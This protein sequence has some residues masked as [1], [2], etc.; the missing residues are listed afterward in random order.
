ML[1]TNA[2]FRRLF[3]ARV[4]SYVGDA[5]A[6]TAL[7]LR[8]EATLGV[9][10]AVGSLL[11][12]HAVPNGL[13]GPVA[14]AVVD[15]VDQRLLMVGADVGRALVFVVIAATLPPFPVLIA[16]MVVVAVLEA[17]F[18]PA[19]RSTIPSLVGRDHLMTA[20]A[21]MV[22]ALN[23]GVALGPLIGGGLV[24]A[25]GFSGALYVNAASFLL[26][27]AF[28]IGLPRIT[29]ERE[30]EEQRLGFFATTREGLA[31]AARDRMMRALSVGMILGVAAAGLDNV[32]LVF[33]A[34]RVFDAGPTGFGALESAFGIGMIV[35]SLLLVKRQP[36]TSSALFVLGWFG[37]AVGNFGV[38]IAP[39]ISFALL[40]Q[41]AGGVGNGVCLVG[42]DTLIQE[43]VPKH[44][45]GR[46]LGVTGSAPFIGMLIAYGSG[47]F[48]VDSFGARRTFLISG[49]ASAIVA[50]VVAVMLARAGR[51]R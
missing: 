24:A 6:L 17:A 45:L 30:R 13:L 48:L 50:V 39:V 4:I 1:R 29:P 2:G 49:T 36:F 46:A 21:W 37:T 19:G 25:I 42:G 9:G 35:A 10:V 32:A 3:L 23:A 12:A 47:G 7:V 5:V 27:A 33:M 41:F 34:T 22:S 18:R 40:A 28:L 51:S 15:R 11:L 31:F 38:G 26:S 16:S 20:N 8:A 14:G 44:M 43:R